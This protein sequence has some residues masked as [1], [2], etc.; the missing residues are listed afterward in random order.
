MK[1]VHQFARELR[2][3]A[4]DDLGLIPALHSY[5]KNFTARVGVRTYLTAFAGVEKLD[6]AQRTALFRVAQEALTNVARHAQASQVEVS[7]EKRGT[8]LCLRIADDGKG[9][10][11]DSA[12]N[13]KKKKR[14]GLLGMKERLEMVGGSFTIE[15][16]PGQGTAIT[17]LIPVETVL[18]K[19]DRLAPRIPARRPGRRDEVVAPEPEAR[20]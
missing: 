18:A 17:A 6:M 11:L 1:I 10:P 12:R 2:P 15:S 5:M 20:G 4:L 14:L 8:A 16:V 3:A 19:L 13:V 7:I 9:L